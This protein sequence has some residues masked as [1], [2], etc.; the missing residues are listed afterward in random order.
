[1]QEPDDRPL[2]HFL[3][4][5]H[6]FQSIDVVGFNNVH[7]I[8]DRQTWK[9]GAREAGRKKKGRRKRNFLLTPILTY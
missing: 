3:K 4:E 1:M 8:S 2:G 9:W 6:F 5:L 7:C